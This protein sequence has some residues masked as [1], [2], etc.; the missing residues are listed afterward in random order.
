MLTA[1][2]TAIASHPATARCWPSTT[3]PA[4]A[5]NTGFTL[6]NTPKNWAG[7]RRRASMSHS[8]GT[9]DDSTPAASASPKAATVR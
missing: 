5:A 9:A 4:S 8:S 2:I 7:T 6:M 1:T 3:R